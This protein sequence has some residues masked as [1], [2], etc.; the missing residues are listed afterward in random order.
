[1]I[2][3]G[4]LNGEL[5]KMWALEGILISNF[6]ELSDKMSSVRTATRYVSWMG[7]TQ[8]QLFY[9]NL[10]SVSEKIKNSDV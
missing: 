3:V 10:I 7:T 1:M 2:N 6:M 5:M 8:S 9:T 4:K